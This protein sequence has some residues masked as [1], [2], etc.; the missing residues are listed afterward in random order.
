MRLRILFGTAA[1]LG[2]LA[3]YALAVVEIAGRLVPGHWAAQALFYAAAGILWVLPAARLTRWMQAAP[4]GPPT[5]RTG[6]AG[7]RAPRSGRSP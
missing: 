4:A 7:T 1:L 5:S 3:F 2:G 6:A